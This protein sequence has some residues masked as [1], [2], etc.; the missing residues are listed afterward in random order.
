[1]DGISLEAP[2]EAPCPETK[3]N[4][5]L[6]VMIMSLSI[7]DRCLNTIRVVQGKGKK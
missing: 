1:M 6:T 7:T 2:Y 4:Y 3:P 5:E